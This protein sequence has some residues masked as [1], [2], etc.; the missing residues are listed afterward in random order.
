[1]QYIILVSRTSFFQVI[2]AF[3]IADQGC[4]GIDVANIDHYTRHIQVTQ[5][6]ARLSLVNPNIEFLG[7]GLQ[8]KNIIAHWYHTA[9]GLMIT[10]PA[11]QHL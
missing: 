1:M 3:T 7:W 4:M 2:L 10:Q 9:E 11:V 5:Q 8:A 6:S